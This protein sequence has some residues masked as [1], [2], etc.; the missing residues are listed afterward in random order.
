LVASAQPQMACGR[1][2]T[3]GRYWCVNPA[4]VGEN[5]DGVRSAQLYMG[6]D[7]VVHPTSQI[8]RASCRTRVLEFVSSGRAFWSARFDE[9]TI[10]ERIGA[11]MCD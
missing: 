11:A 1:D 3:S 9:S 4:S 8:A 5:G 7:R 10:A 2:A 6:N